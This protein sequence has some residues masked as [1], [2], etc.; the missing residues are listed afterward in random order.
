MKLSEDQAVKDA[1]ERES[2]NVGKYAPGEEI[3]TDLVEVMDDDRQSASNMPAHDSDDTGSSLSS[4]S[5]C[6]GVAAT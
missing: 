4:L 3:D 1:I 5:A 6:T 2:L